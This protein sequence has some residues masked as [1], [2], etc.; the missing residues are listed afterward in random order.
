MPSPAVDTMFEQLLQDLPSELEAQTRQFQA[1]SRARKIQTP[2]QLMRVVLL[3][4]GL[5][6]CLRDVAGVF[7]L[8]YEKISDQAMAERL[9]ACRPW[10]RV[11]LTQMLGLEAVVQLPGR[12]RVLVLDGSQVQGPGA[13]GS[14]YRL[15]LALDLVKLT[16]VE[17]HLTPSSRGESLANFTLGPGD[18]ALVDRGYAHPNRIV[19][20]VQ[21][22]AHLVLRLNAHNVPVYGLDGARLDLAQQLKEQGVET[23]HTLPV[24]VK[25]ADGQQS[26]PGQLQAYRLSEA[27]ANQARRRA[28][29]NNSQKGR[30]PKRQTLFLAGW[31]LVFTRLT[32]EQLS[33]QQVLELYRWR[34]Q[35]ELAI[36]RWKS[37]LDLGQLQARFRSPWAELWLQG[38]LL[39]ALLLDKR[40]RRQLGD[41][42]GRLDGERTASWWRPW[43]LLRQQIDPLISGAWGWS[44][45][46]WPQ[47]LQAL[48]E[49]PRHRKLHRLSQDALQ[50]LATLQLPRPQ[51][52]QEVS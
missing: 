6:L 20:T 41:H 10:V 26:L 32:A 50:L 33:A 48:A 13:Q 5:D 39:Y 38:K 51:P 4:C 23:V 31:V 42:W 30:T 25:S 19:E 44:R 46:R 17:I 16:F 3:Y 9:A 34:W 11:L 7:T 15:H 12:G 8:L 27:Q 28:R 45:Q 37:L 43:K 47:C 49:R 22:G 24:V 21:Q 2:R 14:Q 36:K 29:R 18:I 40:M 52:L 1:F 35:V